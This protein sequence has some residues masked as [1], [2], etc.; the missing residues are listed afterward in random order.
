MGRVHICTLTK[1]ENNMKVKWGSFEVK[2]WPGI[3]GH[4]AQPQ[5]PH[6]EQVPQTRWPRPRIWPPSRT[7]SGRACVCFLYRGFEG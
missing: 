7:G 6:S 4:K 2:G 1:R 3:P 5:S